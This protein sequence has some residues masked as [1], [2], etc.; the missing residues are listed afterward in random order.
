[1]NAR[2]IIKET[3]FV[4][5]SANERTEKLCVELIHE[6]LDLLTV[7][8][9][10]QVIREVPFSK[11]LKRSFEI[12]LDSRCRWLY[13]VDADILMRPG[14]IEN[15]LL[16]AEK[17]KRN[18]SQLQSY[19]MDKFFGGVRRGGVHLYRGSLLDKVIRHIPEEG[20]DV[21]PET[22]LLN[23]MTRL[24]YPS[25][26]VPYI[27]GTH[28]DEQYYFDIYRKMFVQGFKHLNRAELL[29]NH[30]KKNVE[31]DSDFE[32]ALRAFSDSIVSGKK[33]YINRNLKIFRDNFKSLNVLEKPE[34]IE[35]FI[36]VQDVE[37]TIKNWHFSDLYNYYFP[38]KDGY[39]S[40]SHKTIQQLKRSVKKRGFFKTSLL[41]FSDLLLKTGRNLKSRVT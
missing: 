37:N 18:V 25:Q 15:M 21:R 28:D 6:Q 32:V 9:D 29:I 39:D 3:V 33:I 38:D 5:R 1:M 23:K 4:I 7:K 16:Y 30:W 40:A 36:T 31:K 19:M 10:V 12:G 27:I 2:E 26:V 24:G 13:S 8:S 11:A 35:N 17:S 22:Y 34:L 14:S 41:S 20:V